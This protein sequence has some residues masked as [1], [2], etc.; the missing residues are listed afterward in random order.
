MPGFPDL[1]NFNGLTFPDAQLL[2]AVANGGDG[3]VNSGGRPGQA[4][5]NIQFASDSGSI[6]GVG[7]I[8][9]LNTDFTEGRY[10]AGTGIYDPPKY[11][12]ASFGEIQLVNPALGI[13]STY[14]V[15][16]FSENGLLLSNAANTYWHGLSLYNAP[17]GDSAGIW[18]LGFYGI[19]TPEGT[20]VLGTVFGPDPDDFAV[21]PCFA[22]GTRIETVSGPVA[23][24]D[25]AVGDLL[26]TASG[27][28]RPIKWIGRTLTGT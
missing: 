24:E 27:A 9:V 4:Q 19:N 12:L 14:Y 5:G 18:V 17:G 10:V 11:Y 28:Q 3:M 6:Q 8:T 22:E 7:Q 20:Q 25:L 21:A 1:M 16:G 15:H 13:A 2:N 26:V 23:V